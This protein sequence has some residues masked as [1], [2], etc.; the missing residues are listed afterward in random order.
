MRVFQEFEKEHLREFLAEQ[1][2]PE[3]ILAQPANSKVTNRIRESYIIFR[4]F[5]FV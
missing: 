3:P 2:D 4:V 5:E 1:P